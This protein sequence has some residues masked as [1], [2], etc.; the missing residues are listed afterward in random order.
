MAH[1]STVSHISLTALRLAVQD[2][3]LSDVDCAALQHDPRAGARILWAQT[4][5]RAAKDVQEQARL[6]VLMRHERALWARGLRHVGGLDEVGVGPLLGPVV[7]AVVVLPPNLRIEGV[8]D[9]KKLSAAKRVALAKQIH[10]C[11]VGVGMGVCS[12]LEIDAM[13]IYRAT[14]EAMRRAVMDVTCALDHVLV[15]AH[16]VPGIR[17]PQTAIIGGDRESHAIAAASIVAKVARDSMMAELDAEFPQYGL[18]RHKGYG[19]AM[20]LE[21]LSRLGPTPHHRQSF[22]PVRAASLAR[23]L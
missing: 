20:H 9:S 22:A 10:R 2:G 3:S 13:N 7:A 4:Q 23:G 15:D 17:V 5:A 14:R 16:R 1:S 18:A 12:A 8:D 21:A 6:Q 11:A 19:T